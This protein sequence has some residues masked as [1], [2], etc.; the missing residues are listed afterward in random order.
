MEI[1]EIFAKRKTKL[2]NIMSARKNTNSDEIIECKKC[3]GKFHKKTLLK[4]YMVCPDCNNYFTMT[5]FERIGM[6]GDD[7]SFK[8]HLS[9]MHTINPL[10]FPGYDE[11]LKS[12][13]QKSGRDEA[14]VTGIIK[15]GGITCGIGIMDSRFMM[16]SMGTVV[17]ERITAITEFC[18][19]QSL[20]LIIFSASGGARMQEGMF[21]LMQ[22]AK[23][24]AAIKKFKNHGGL[25]ISC[26]TNPTTGG[27]SASFAA[28]G[29]IEIA[30]PDALICFAGPR[31]IEQTIN[32]SLPQGFQ[33]SEFLLKM[34]MLD[35]ICERRNMKDIIYKLLLIHEV[36]K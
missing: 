26:Y 29:D 21:S 35:M 3:H 10:D 27:V 30:E 5:P 36:R 20:P 23:T 8:E 7:H 17:G 19:K 24:T 4:N 28:L 2:K 32:E 22:M 6:I 25:Y 13:R 16:G 12:A 33:H 11:K 18:D 9:R 14:V 15:I 31:V 1:Y 34:G